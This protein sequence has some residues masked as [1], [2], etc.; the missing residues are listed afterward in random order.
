MWKINWSFDEAQIA[1]VVIPPPPPPP[2]P[3]SSSAVGTGPVNS[4][5]STVSPSAG[6]SGV[7]VGTKSSSNV[8]AAT[9]STA[10]S[11]APAPLVVF[12]L[13][14]LTGND[15]RSSSASIG[16]SPPAKAASGLVAV[17]VLTPE[18]IYSIIGVSG[19]LLILCIV[20]VCVRRRNR[21]NK[22]TNE[23][24]TMG[25]MRSAVDQTGIS[26][27]RLSVGD[28]EGARAKALEATFASFISKG[29][30][31][32]NTTM[33]GAY[34]GGGATDMTDA[35]QFVTEMGISV[36]GYLQ[37]NYN[38]DI[39]IEKVLTKGG[40]GTIYIAQAMNPKLSVYGDKVIVKEMRYT[41]E[42]EEV[43][44]QFNLELSL[45]EYFKECPYVAKVLGYTEVPLCL[46]MKQYKF[47]S[48]RTYLNSDAK[49]FLAVSLIFS[50][51]I[52][53]GILALHKK[54]VAHN[55]MKPENILMDQEPE[56]G[57]LMCVLTDFGVSA[58]V[59]DGLLTVNAL[60]ITEL[61]A[62]SLKYAAPERLICYTQNLPIKSTAAVLSGDIFAAGII[63]FELLNKVKLY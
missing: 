27:N 51:D 49:R 17:L 55:D 28:Y 40:G 36:P 61:R 60:K 62:F 9:V 23:E 18:I 42:S 39:R 56:T 8:P 1:P 25:S 54:G 46:I 16:K 13:P 31:S 26:D 21:S 45:M 48:L 41:I 59:T 63:M 52:A 12:S 15:V 11:N 4:V 35:T 19:A 43:K 50:Q 53:A 30:E 3:K 29:S 47:G 33:T 57:R 20:I 37:F 24:Y 5:L 34:E 22:N 7:V 14:P 2:A 6:A 38:S 44:N 58:V 32:S 10:G